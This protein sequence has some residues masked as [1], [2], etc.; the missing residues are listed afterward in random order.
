M[1]VKTILLSLRL[2]VGLCLLT[3]S[4]CSLFRPNPLA[5]KH[6]AIV[7]VFDM[8]TAGDLKSLREMLSR[9]NACATFFAAGQVSRATAGQLH[10]LQDDGHLIGVSGLKGGKA[11]VY[12][13]MY[14]L[15]KYFQDEFVTQILDA[16]RYDIDP[17]YVLVGPLE[18]P[19]PSPME[20]TTFLCRKGFSRVVHLLPDY[21][22]LRTLPAT[23]LTDPV[24]HVYPLTEKNFDHA[25]VAAL[26][27][28]N[29]VLV[30]CANRKI[31]PV[32]LE[33]ARTQGVPFATIADL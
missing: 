16:R 24:L 11:Q 33:E 14:G 27:R 5:E 32:L 7:L 26:A 8:R 30:V 28:R 3:L 18:L 25:Q 22:P 2:A 4:G 10:N 23:R 6:G 9:Y 13:Q 1:L 17:R 15:Q 21:V 29:E 20:L 19:K 31:L 12:C